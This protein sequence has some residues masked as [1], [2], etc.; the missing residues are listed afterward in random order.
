MKYH[1]DKKI[2]FINH[3]SFSEDT[4]PII[5]EIEEKENNDNIECY[6]IA[7]EHAQDHKGYGCP[8]AKGTCLLK[9][10]LLSANSQQNI[11]CFVHLRG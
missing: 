2:V 9:Y 1:M 6:Q 4:D 5:N 11:S 10:R 7:L 3:G 8:L